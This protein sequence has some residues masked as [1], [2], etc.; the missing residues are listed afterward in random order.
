MQLSDIPEILPLLT[1]GAPRTAFG[2]VTC[3]SR[4]VRPGDLFVALAGTHADGARFAAAA[5]AKGASLIL[6]ETQPPGCPAAAFAPVADPRRAY[7]ILT[8]AA[9]GWPCRRLSVFGVTGTN[10][11]TTTAWILGELLRAGRRDP[12]LVTTVQIS[13]GTR[14]I[15]SV[16]TT[17][18]A[19]ELQTRFAEML[20]AGCDSAVME[21]SSHSIDQQRIGAV[22]FAGVGFTNLS[23]DHLDYHRT[24]AAYEAVKRRLFSQAAS[25]T[26]GIPA[27]CCVETESGRR[28]AAYIRTL[29]LKLVTCGFDPS[30]DIRAK[31]IRLTPDGSAFTLVLP[32]AEPAPL[33]YRLA[34]RY[35]ISNLLLAIALAHSAGVPPE[36]IAAAVPALAP[37]WG[38]LER[39]PLA[40]P[41]AVFV[42]YAHTDDAL[43]HV[44]A[45]LREMNPAHLTVV[46]GCGGDRD[47]TKRPKMGAACARRADRLIVTSDNP[48][49]E[50]PNAIISEILPGIPAG[51]DLHI[52]SDRRAAIRYALEHAGAGDIVLVAGK[53]HETYQEIAGR[54][55]PFDDRKV[56]AEEG[57]GG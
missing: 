23:Q 13:Y 48:R 12:G 25:E 35:N 45:T 27:A 57:A 38:R 34:G 36:A 43:D 9:A 33:R 55:L 44:L 49:T 28:M 50:D 52:E 37:R 39:V 11:K 31:D 47:R 4:R 46:F 7:A 5:L 22:R 54:M 17:P 8:A 16:R 10:G 32:G 56:V 20:A 3:D 42:D 18:D 26:P 2:G 19:G 6:G 40:K 1:G 41:F 21:V 51:T 15:P 53:G 14:V 30:A 24:M 29:P